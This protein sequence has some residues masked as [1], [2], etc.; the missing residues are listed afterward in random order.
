[1]DMPSS[2]SMGSGSSMSNS[3][4]SSMSSMD[5]MKMYFHFTPG[6]VLLFDTIAPSSA[7]AVFGACLIFFL[8]SIFYRWLRA[9]GRGV[10]YSFAARANRLALNRV[11]SEHSSDRASVT[12]GLTPAEAAP[13]TLQI[14]N[15]KFIFSSEIARGV[16]AGLEETLHYL[17][18]LVVMTF[19]V[20]YIISIIL[21]VVV[22]EIAFG[23]LN[24][25]Y[26]L[27]TGQGSCCG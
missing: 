10:E 8:I 19:N 4:M 11:D 18:M 12:K 20:S 1:M 14:S 27:A 22:G 2:S 25:N 5:M 17:L 13:N 21:G 24:R 9:F 7:G 23:R 6:D 15:P 26:V 16:L 3:T